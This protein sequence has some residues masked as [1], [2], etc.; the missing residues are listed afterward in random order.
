MIGQQT[1][2]KTF[3]EAERWYYSDMDQNMFAVGIGQ[4]DRYYEFLQ[5]IKGRFDAVREPFVKINADLQKGML[6]GVRPV[7]EE[8]WKAMQE[9]S[10]L[11][12]SIQLDIESFYVFAKITLDKIANFLERYFGPER[13][14]SFRS[15][16]NLVKHFDKYR[17]AKGLNIP[18]EFTELAATLKETV[19]DF[20]DKQIEHHRNPRRTVGIAWTS[21]G[22]LRL[23]PI[24]FN[25]K[26]GD[27]EQKLSIPL[28]LTMNDLDRY[29]ESVFE[30]I[31]RDRAKGTYSIRDKGAKS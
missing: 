25:P 2:I 13:G 20:R 21:D 6:P 8:E 14:C 12:K 31:R 26:E 5:I 29:L 22:N 24:H 18:N 10:I 3:R 15:H 23:T 4:P 30:L 28:S 16:D 11:Q 1:P 19:S 27:Q 17:D 9:S 7:T